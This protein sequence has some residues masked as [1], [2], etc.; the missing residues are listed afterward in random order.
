MGDNPKNIKEILANDSYI[1]PR[2][3]R[4]YAWGKSEISQLIKDIEE[5]FPKANTE[6]KSYY[7]GSLVCFKR[8]NGS[9][10]LVDGQQRHTTKNQTSQT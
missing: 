7:L 9:F 2:Y 8:E 3:Q 6:D 1:I 10:E 5:F 4:N